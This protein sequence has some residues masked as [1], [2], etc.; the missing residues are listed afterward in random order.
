MR[1][2]LVTRAGHAAL[3]AAALAWFLL[4]GTVPAAKATRIKE[5]A[6]IE[7]IRDNQLIGYGL[8][9]GLAGTGDGV[10]TQ[11]TV[12]TLR[13]MLDRM[14]ISLPPAMLRVTN[15]A[16]VMITG[17]LAPFAQP[18][19]KLDVT[20]SAMGDASNLQGGVL[21]LTP[22]RGVNG[23]I[24][25]VAQGPMSTGGFV[26][27]RQ[28]QGNATTRNHPTTA[29]IPNG[30]IVERAA[31]SVMPGKEVRLQLRTSDFTNAARIVEAINAKFPDA[32][33]PLAVAR[34]AGLVA[35]RAPEDAP[36]GMA[37]FIA[38]LEALEIDAEQRAGI[39]VN[40]RTG[41]VIVGS[42]VKVAPVVMMHGSLSIEV[43]TRY[44]VSQPAPFAKGETKVVP[45]VNV[46]VREEEARSV[47]L[48]DGATVDDLV[49]AL[50]TIG[51]TP[52]DI[53][54]ILQS[55]KAAGALDVDLQ[56]I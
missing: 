50:N 34:N 31:P 33:S 28:A 37:G 29:R 20:V 27:G 32:A 13:N 39:V 22:L 17:T 7:G 47:S 16:A 10:Q 23:E 9:V 26:A 12:Q 41:T 18:G 52:R 19:S 43:Q 36:G 8:V 35:V 51:V 53:I 44:D 11:F 1:I 55:L 21:L 42:Q 6:Q 54:A 25:A 48:K 4:W 14:G 2:K 24:Y 5:L 56:V 38:A 15:T 46:Q 49:R 3:R 40:E 30:A 45:E